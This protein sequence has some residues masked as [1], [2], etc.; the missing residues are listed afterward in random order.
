MKPETARTAAVL[1]L[2]AACLYVLSGVLPAIAWAGLLAVSTWPLHERIA[3]R[4]GQRRGQ[5]VSAALLTCVAVLALLLPLGWLVWQGLHE[6]PVVLRVWTA[7]K[8]TGL[9]APDWLGSLPGIGAWAL[10]QWNQWIAQPGALSEAVHAM[11]GNLHLR[12][13]R[14]LV[15][16]LGHAAM[17]LFFCVLLLYFLYRDGDVLARQIETVLLRRFGPV[18]VRR[19]QRAVRAARGTVNGLVLVGLAVA[20]VMSVAYAVAGM[21]QPA[22]WGI[23]TGLLGM[24]PFGAGV[25]LAGVVLYLLAAGA[26][27]AALVLGAFGA[28]LIFVVD[29]FVRPLFIAGSSRLPLVMALLGIVAGLETFGVLGIFLGPTLLAVMAA[30]WR[31]MASEPQAADPTPA[32]RPDT[33][34]AETAERR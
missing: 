6:V 12:T 30:V 4:L 18:G 11:A 31:D 20:V 19:M 22:L 21:P 17:S 32:G 2:L 33:N 34:P 23:V 3:R 16:E 10:K 14:L 5:G 25:A 13:G 29:H 1:V 8:D 27:T 9:P 24:V 15:R 7:S 26:G 28:V